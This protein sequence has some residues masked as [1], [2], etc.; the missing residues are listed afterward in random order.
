MELDRRMTDGGN[1]SL[2]W[3][4]TPGSIWSSP[5]GRKSI[6]VQLDT[7]RQTEQRAFYAFTQFD[8][9]PRQSTRMVT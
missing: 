1:T 5:E 3:F 2:P 4:V 7:A 6:P 9:V 8:R